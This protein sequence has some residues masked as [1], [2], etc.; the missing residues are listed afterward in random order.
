MLN[1]PLVHLLCHHGCYGVLHSVD[2]LYE[3]AAAEN[4][5]SGE[6]VRTFCEHT[7]HGE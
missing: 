4:P 3:R 2:E 7:H 5:V 6:L 1:D